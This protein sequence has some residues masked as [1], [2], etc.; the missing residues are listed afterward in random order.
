MTNNPLARKAAITIIASDV[1]AGVIIAGCDIPTLRLLIDEIKDIRRTDRHGAAQRFS[2]ADYDRALIRCADAIAA[3][4]NLA[5]EPTIR[6][7]R[8]ARA[9]IDGTAQA[10]TLAQEGPMGD[11]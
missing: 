9:L 2:D 3:Q 5:S 11:E 6:E 8:E 4:R 10:G 7:S 1:S